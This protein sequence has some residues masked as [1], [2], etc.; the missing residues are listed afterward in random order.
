MGLPSR[1]AEVVARGKRRG[2]RGVPSLLAACPPPL[3][4]RRLPLAACPSPLTPRGM[5]PGAVLARVIV[6][7]P[8]LPVLAHPHQRVAP[9]G[10]L[11][12]RERQQEGAGHHRVLP[13][14]RRHAQVREAEGRL[15]PPTL[16]EA[17]L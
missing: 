12:V 2:A 9:A 1:G 16:P 17:A 7:H 5:M 8:P 4:P 3:A 11:A 15:R 10:G 6:H 13:P 14:E